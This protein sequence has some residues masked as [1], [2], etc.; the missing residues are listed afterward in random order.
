MRIV[1]RQQKMKAPCPREHE[2][3]VTEEQKAASREGIGARAG[4]QVCVCVC[5]CVCVSIY[6][7]YIYIY[8]HKAVPQL[9]AH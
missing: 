1:K 8:R 3:V 9:P 7:I 2:E 6:I 4:G 5:L